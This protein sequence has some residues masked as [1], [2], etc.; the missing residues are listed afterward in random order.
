MAYAKMIFLARDY[1]TSSFVRSIRNL[2]NA[3]STYLRNNIA[4]NDVTKEFCC[5]LL[6]NVFILCNVFIS[7]CI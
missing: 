4:I 7:I 6:T 1:Y 3:R 5:I 2:G